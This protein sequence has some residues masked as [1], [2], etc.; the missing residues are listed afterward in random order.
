MMKRVQVI[1]SG[2]VQGVGFRYTVKEA[3][4]GYEIGGFVKNLTNGDVEVVAEAQEPDITRFL[5]DIE[6]EMGRFIESRSL[7]WDRATG[8]FDGFSVRY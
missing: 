5:A 8:E 3:A 1:Y 7:S 4:S 6:T 2:Q